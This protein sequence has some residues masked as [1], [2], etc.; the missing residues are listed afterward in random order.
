MKRTL[1]VLTLVAAATSPLAAQGRAPV[2]PT[3]T[4]EQETAANA[5]ELGVDLFRYMAPQLGTAIAGGNATLGQGGSLGGLGRFALGVRANAVFGSLPNI[6]EASIVPGAPDSQSYTTSNQVIPMPV[7]DAAFGLFKGLPLGVT[8]VGGIDVLVNA[9]YVPAFSNEQFDL[10][11]PDGSLKVGYGARVGLLQE[12]LV[13]PGVSFTYMKRDLPTATLTGR[14]NA[15]TTIVA[16]D[17]A[18]ET[19]AWRVVASKNLLFFG[20]ALG[21]GQDTYDFSGSAT[22]TVTGAGSASTPDLGFS[23]KRTNYFAN[24]NM[25]ILLAK[26]VGEIGMVQGGEVQTFNTFD[27]PADDKRLY[28]SVGF[29]IGL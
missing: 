17:L 22:G 27:K 20:L 3:G 28:G 21:A 9:A 16:D 24:L 23:M 13:S 4:I 18:V 8:S 11:L 6:D 25:N 12:S 5:C 1:F 7:F 26:I 19:T 29:R 10:E 14:P 15:N 2:C